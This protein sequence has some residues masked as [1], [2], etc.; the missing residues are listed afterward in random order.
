MLPSL[1]N[2]PTGARNADGSKKSIS[3]APV[4]KFEEFVR[5]NC[6]QVPW[7][8]YRMQK[9]ESKRIKRM[10]SVFPSW[11]PDSHQ[12]RSMENNP[13][14]YY[15]HDVLADRRLDP[16]VRYNERNPT[17]KAEVQQ[18]ATQ[19]SLKHGTV[20]GFVYH[21]V[22]DFTEKA[23]V[24]PVTGQVDEFARMCLVPE[25]SRPVRQRLRDA[26]EHLDGYLNE[27]F[28]MSDM[29]R[30]AARY[31][32]DDAPPVPWTQKQGIIDWKEFWMNLLQKALDHYAMKDREEAIR[33]AQAAVAG[34]GRN[35]D[36]DMRPRQRQRLGR[37]FRRGP[38]S[39]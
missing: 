24:D 10:G 13:M 29:K 5:K 11:V 18:Y 38:W 7:T 39:S 31:E 4:D 27:E 8:M 2:L 34:N 16:E 21:W 30:E 17:A 1:H 32:D 9:P 25:Q 20:P 36:A 19:E 35:Y 33:S 14:G 12:Y 22:M 6:V 37:A 23:Y 28:N 3:F 26:V 15:L